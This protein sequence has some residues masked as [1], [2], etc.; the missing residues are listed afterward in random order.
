MADASQSEHTLTAS[1]YLMVRGEWNLPRRYR[2]SM[3]DSVAV[4]TP[5][6]SRAAATAIPEIKAYDGPGT[7]HTLSLGDACELDWIDDGSVHLVVTSPPYFNLKKYNDHPRQLGDVDDYEHFHD[8]LDRVWRHCFRALVPG[9]RL[10]V[11]VGDVCVARRENGGRH[12]VFPL[13]ADIA[14][15]ARRIGFDYLTP[16]CGT[17]SPTRGSRRKATVAAFSESRTS[18]TASSRTMSS[19]SSCSASRASTAARQKHS[20]LRPG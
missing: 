11:N 15:R 5:R 13:H 20:G 17:R 1:E 18:P 19:T 7:T 10:V 3:D 4:T 2:V 12:H 14:V 6:R 9:G 16:S 8:E